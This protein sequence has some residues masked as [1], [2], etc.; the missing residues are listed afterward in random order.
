MAR[1]RS[2]NLIPPGIYY[3]IFIF[4]AVSGVEMKEEKQRSVVYAAAASTLSSDFNFAEL[5]L[6]YLD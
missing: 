5:S 2:K 1:K 6:F 3:F 4:I